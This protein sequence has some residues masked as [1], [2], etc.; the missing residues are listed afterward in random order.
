MA[1]GVTNANG[2]GA[3]V[4]IQNTVVKVAGKDSPL[5]LFR[6]DDK[7]LE[8]E[9]VAAL[10]GVSGDIRRACLAKLVGGADQKRFDHAVYV[11]TPL[12]GG[13]SKIGVS[14]SPYKRLAELQA[15]SHVQLRISHLFW[16]PSK[17]AFG[18]EGLSLRV[19]GRMGSRLHGEWVN[20]AHDEAAIVVA[21]ILGASSVEYSTSEMLVRN[22]KA[23]GEVEVSPMGADEGLCGTPRRAIA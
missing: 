5:G 3:P 16:M 13:A 4:K 23:I 14:Q 18:I 8:P 20:M 21:A 12:D 1:D 2:A 11:I 17:A 7:G 9:D 6:L 19:I 15:G 10:C 22:L